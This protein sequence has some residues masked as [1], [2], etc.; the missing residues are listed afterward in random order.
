MIHGIKTIAMINPSNSNDSFVPSTL[1]QMDTA[2]RKTEQ[3]VEY[4]TYCIAI[5]IWI[6]IYLYTVT[7]Y[8]FVYTNSHYHYKGMVTRIYACTLAPILQ[9]RRILIVLS[10]VLYPLSPTPQKNII[11]RAWLGDW[12]VF[13]KWQLFNWIFHSIHYIFKQAPTMHH[14]YDIHMHGIHKSASIKLNCNIIHQGFLRIQIR[15]IL[16]QKFPKHVDAIQKLKMDVI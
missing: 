4:H 1:P 6:I 15:D 9:T 11:W 5:G 7:F 12:E 3:C 8:G 10:L 13:G 2:V 16:S 14:A